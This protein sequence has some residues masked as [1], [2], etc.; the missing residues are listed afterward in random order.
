MKKEKDIPLY[1]S[2]IINTYIK[3][4]K[5]NY[6]YVDV[7]DL[8]HYAKMESYQVEDVGHWF[9]QTQINRFH[10]KLKTLTGNIEIAREAGRYLASPEATGLLRQ[11]ILGLVSLP[12]VYEIAG[13]A[14]SK[15]TRSSSYSSKKIGS[16]QIELS[17]S[18]N[19]GVKEEPF[20]C[21]NR[22]G[23][24][25]ALAKIFNYKSKKIE[26]P[27][28]VFKG[29]T[30]CRYIIS[31]NESPAT[32]L[33]TIR[34]YATLLFSTFCLISAFFAPHLTLITFLPASAI[35]LLLMSWYA[36]NSE[37]R[38]LKAAV[39]SLEGSSEKL[40][41]Q[42]DI[43]YNN[44]LMINEIGEA[45]SKQANIDGILAKVIQIL[46]KRLDYDRG[47][48]L[49]ANQDRTQLIFRTG[50]GYLKNQVR[51]LKKAVF[52]LDKPDSKGIFV[53]SFKKQ[54]PFLIND[55]DEIEGLMTAHSLE[56]AK[57]MG[58]KSFI[59]CPIV[60]EKE[61]LGI[62]AVD[63]IKSKKPLVQSDINLL[64]GIA[65][66]IGISMYNASLRDAEAEQFKSILHVLAASI[67]AR[68]PLTAG[69]SEKVTEYALGICHEMKLSHDYCEMVRVASLLHD[70]GK[71]GIED[72]ILKK[73]GPLEP[74]EYEKIKTHA[75]KTNKILHQINFQGIYKQVP[76][77]AGFH[78]EKINGSGYPNGLKGE[79]IPLGSQI[80]A[81]AD[82]F[83]AIT[84]KRHYRDPMHLDIAFDL[85]ENKIDIFFK[86]EIV[87]ALISYYKRE[88][89]DKQPVQLE[90]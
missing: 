90:L 60:Y 65:P 54:E 66:Q 20:Q 84:S 14:A 30:S 61:T 18:P 44:A 76:E 57:A 71:I 46:E 15:F 28:C 75:T 13:K 49:L 26:H 58:V 85:L 45:L 79:E 48:I 7:N 16:N 73:Q 74:D 42:I 43:N 52:H 11:Y 9:T 33:K 64:M 10:E 78:H 23:Y 67:D 36:G 82:F 81:V 1:N 25:E 87:E 68:D 86:R 5:R 83:E 41:D 59:C 3:F 31:W 63:N 22:L 27:E 12:K 77:I 88:Y 37:I 34:A 56:F 6:S 89:K 72:A 69:H 19:T 62:L 40:I 24:I 50:Y 55:I 21:E 53:V 17:V 2:R 39:T 4:I 70:Y 32:I 38:E 51:F 29:G 47:M 8:L 80:I 35:I